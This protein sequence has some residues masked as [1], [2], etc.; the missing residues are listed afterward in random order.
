MSR[1]PSIIRREGRTFKAGQRTRFFESYSCF[2][3]YPRVQ[4]V[5]NTSQVVREAKRRGKCWKVAAIKR[6]DGSDGFTAYGCPR[7]GRFTIFTVNIVNILGG[8]RDRLEWREQ[9]WEA[10]ISC[11]A[12]PNIGL[13][14]TDLRPAPTAVTF[15]G[16]AERI[17]CPSGPFLNN[18]RASTLDKDGNSIKNSI[19][20]QAG[21]GETAA[22]ALAR[23]LSRGIPASNEDEES[24]AATLAGTDMSQCT[25]PVRRV[26]ALDLQ[27]Q[28]HSINIPH[29]EIPRADAD[30]DAALAGA[31]DKVDVEGAHCYE[32]GTCCG[33]WL[34][35]AGLCLSSPHRQRHVHAHIMPRRTARVAPTRARHAPFTRLAAT[36]SLASPAPAHA[37]NQSRGGT[38][39]VCL[40]SHG[41]AALLSAWPPAI[42]A[43][44]P[45]GS[46]FVEARPQRRR[47]AGRQL[48]RR[49]PINTARAVATQ[50]TSS[51][52]APVQRSR[53]LANS[54]APRFVP[55]E[56]PRLHDFGAACHCCVL[57][58]ATPSALSAHSRAGAH[59]EQKHTM[60]VHDRL[61][62]LP[63]LRLL[64]ACRLPF[65]PCA[66]S[67]T[68]SSAPATRRT[69]PTTST[70]SFSA[71]RAMRGA[72]PRACTVH[73]PAQQKLA[74]AEVAMHARGGGALRSP[75]SGGERGRRGVPRGAH[76]G[77]RGRSTSSTRDTRPSGARSPART[78]GLHHREM[79]AASCA[80]FNSNPRAHDTP[81]SSRDVEARMTTRTRTPPHTTTT[82]HSTSHPDFDLPRHTTTS[83]HHPPPAPAGPAARLSPP[84][85]ERHAHAYLP[86]RPTSHRRR[87]ASPPLPR[88]SGI[89][90][91]GR[92]EMRTPTPQHSDG[93][94]T[95]VRDMTQ[96]HR[97][98][99]F[100]FMVGR[101][102][103]QQH[104][105]RGA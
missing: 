77:R 74:S 12:H 47:H 68:R 99:R 81:A 10:K 103:A 59:P 15:D 94:R 95:R 28:Q 65:L 54:M 50:H 35:H 93:V 83:E 82:P 6:L 96:A 76:G 48:P 29:H 27:L 104:L 5:Q 24:V 79:A 41:P 17:Q 80:Q 69:S 34:G 67:P 91:F 14:R 60:P 21:G 36:P 52:S 89:S 84:H 16:D 38:S 92:A 42:Y 22:V 85:H 20:P 51:H 32:L 86:L 43:R 62:A 64:R 102:H 100:V 31:R 101:V 19:P 4:V 7:G 73:S 87:S 13:L 3:I 25:R 53:S 30:C 98:G 37:P 78:R 105:F 9:P 33:S 75:G 45:P 57:K 63:R 58:A 40:P 97:V 71:R 70:T 72:E 18:S 39:P 56:A 26:A 2:D 11:Q 61:A 1:H 23:I 49:A 88:C 90:Y 66:P 8:S 46:S 44:P 55:R